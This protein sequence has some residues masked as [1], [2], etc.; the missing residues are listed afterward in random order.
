MNNNVGTM[1]RNHQKVG[2]MVKGSHKM[3]TMSRANKSVGVN[4][5][6]S[7]QQIEETSKEYNKYK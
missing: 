2:Q 5:A 4:N 7:P 6:P 3:G 1:S